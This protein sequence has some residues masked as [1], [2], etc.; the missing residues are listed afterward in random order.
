MRESE[1]EVI[2]YGRNGD[3]RREG[4]WLWTEQGAGG[5]ETRLVS[6]HMRIPLLEAA[7]LYTLITGLRLRLQMEGALESPNSDLSSFPK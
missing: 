4:V 1:E 6:C 2:K 5:T 3:G 7:S